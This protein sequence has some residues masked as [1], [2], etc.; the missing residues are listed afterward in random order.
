MLKQQEKR[1]SEQEE[2]LKQLE[3]RIQELKESQKQ[4]LSL[5]KPQK[6]CEDLQL[7][8]SNHKEQR[9]QLE[10]EQD[11]VKTQLLLCHL[12]YCEEEE[13]EEAQDYFSPET[14]PVSEILREQWHSLHL[15]SKQ[16]EKQQQ[17]LALQ[18]NKVTSLL[19]AVNEEMNRQKAETALCLPS[20]SQTDNLAELEVW[21]KKADEVST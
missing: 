2:Q 12:Q 6:V 19:E 1:L 3:K 5:E 7:W 8:K 18:E 20:P 17:T 15:Q 10:Q 21:E 11:E 13:N 4:E 16:L 14:T 9:L